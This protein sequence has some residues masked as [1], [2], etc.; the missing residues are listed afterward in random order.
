MEKILGTLE[1]VCI[2]LGLVL[3]CI[4]YRTNKRLEE[5]DRENSSQ[6]SC[7]WQILFILFIGSIILSP[8][9]VIMVLI[10]LIKKKKLLK[11]ALEKQNA[12]LNNNQEQI[13]DKTNTTEIILPSTEELI[14]YTKTE[15]VITAYSNYEGEPYLYPYRIAYDG[16]VNSGDSLILLK[17]KGLTNDQI[18]IYCEENGYF[19]YNNPPS[20][21]FIK[22]GTLLFTLYKTQE[23]LQ[24]SLYKNTLIIG[25]DDFTH[26]KTISGISFGGQNGFSLPYMTLTAEYCNGYHKFCIAYDSK[27][28][29][30]SKYHTLHLLLNNGEIVTLSNFTT[31]IKTTSFFDR[32]RLVYSTVSLNDIIKLSQADFI[33]WQIINKEGVVENEGFYNEDAFNL[34]RLAFKDFFS[35]YINLYEQEINEETCLEENNTTINKTCFVYLMIDTTNGFHKIGISNNPRYREHTLQSDKPTIELLYAKEFPTRKMAEAL[36]STLHKT[37]ESKRIRGEWFNLTSQDIEEIKSVLQ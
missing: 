37:Y 23:S 3:Y 20:F 1:L 27:K 13:S 36:E 34:K 32:N 9:A 24:N 21:Y 22:K 33:K 31:P 29:C 5:I 16:Y 12:L 6:Q 7:L 11:K 10:P 14:S 25:K 19:L 15:D 26:K 35:K 17:T 18:I 2:I 4:L 30:L 28:I 8:I